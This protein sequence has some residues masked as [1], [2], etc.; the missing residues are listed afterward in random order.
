MRKAKNPS[1]ALKKP[2]TAETRAKMSRR[3]T[4]WWAQRKAIQARPHDV[5]A[6]MEGAGRNPP[7]TPQP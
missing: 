6:R 5:L 3:R 7:N 1:A 2:V 4:Q